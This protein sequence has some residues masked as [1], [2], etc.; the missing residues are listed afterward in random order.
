MKYD[1]IDYSSYNNGIEQLA[2]SLEYSKSDLSHSDPDF[3][4]SI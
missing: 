1:E 2:K 3:F 4:S